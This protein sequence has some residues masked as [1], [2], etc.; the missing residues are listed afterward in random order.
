M[1]T[2]TLGGWRQYLAENSADRSV[3]RPLRFDMRTLEE[4]KLVVARPFNI[5]CGCRILE[6]IENKGEHGAVVA[7]PSLGNQSASRRSVNGD[8]ISTCELCGPS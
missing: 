3:I 7:N 4:R 2:S 6:L 8:R 5:D 1:N